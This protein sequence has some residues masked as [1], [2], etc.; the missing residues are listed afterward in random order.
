[1]AFQFDIK[2]T[3]TNSPLVW[4]KVIVP[5]DF[6]FYRLHLVIQAVFG[7]KNRHLFQFCPG[8]HG[9]Q[10]LI[11]M[12]GNRTDGEYLDCKKTKVN[13]IFTELEQKFAYIYDFGDDWFHSITL[14]GI[15]D[16]QLTN[17]DCIDGKGA[18]PPEDCGGAG[19]YYRLKR[20]MKFAGQPGHEEMRQWLKLPVGQGWNANYFDLEKTRARLQKAL[21]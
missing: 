18:C 1:M 3:E 19:G 14:E 16:Q 8:D 21:S 5:E 4:R 10:P 9:S 11:T 7:W 6:T 13:E 2:L 15:T 17:A 20:V 12:A